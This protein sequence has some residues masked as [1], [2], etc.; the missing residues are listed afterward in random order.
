[1]QLLDMKIHGVRAK[2]KLIILQK[3]RQSH[4]FHNISLDT[5]KTYENARECRSKAQALV[6]NYSAVFI[7]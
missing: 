6:L 5:S 1:M 7:L 2:A 3:G 4:P